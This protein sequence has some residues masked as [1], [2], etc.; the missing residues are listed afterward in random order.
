[1]FRRLLTV[2]VSEMHEA[3][4]GRCRKAFIFKNESWAMTSSPPG[5][6]RNLEMSSYPFFL[7]YLSLTHGYSSNS[8]CFDVANTWKP[9]YKPVSLPLPKISKIH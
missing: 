5:E 2:L 8:F 6:V 9:K 7:R 1:M 4:Q 3:L